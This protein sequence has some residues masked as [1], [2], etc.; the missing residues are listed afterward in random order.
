MSFRACFALFAL[1]ACAPSG[2]DELLEEQ[3]LTVEAEGKGDSVVVDQRSDDLSV[4][5]A[6]ATDAIGGD[7]APG[8]RE[9]ECTPIND[10][11]MDCTSAFE[12][13]YGVPALHRI[14]V[15]RL[16]GHFY[17]RV[18]YVETATKQGALDVSD[19]IGFFYRGYGSEGRFVPRDRLVQ[20][21]TAT[22]LDGAPMAVHRFAGFANCWNGSASSSSLAT[23]T[24]KPFVQFDSHDGTLYRNWDAATDYVIKPS[25]PSFDR[26]SDVTR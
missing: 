17:C 1:T 6:N 5:R 26:A 11:S 18:L 3:S 23:Y 14:S 10:W 15:P 2:G 19:G 24:F 12:A 8:F 22:R 20:V 9:A 7:G 25:F 13:R 16:S 4:L 21:G